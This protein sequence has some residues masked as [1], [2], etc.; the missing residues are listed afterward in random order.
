LKSGAFVPSASILVSTD[1][2]NAFRMVMVALRLALEATRLGVG[3]TLDSI[4]IATTC[5]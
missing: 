4:A 5:V 1:C 3:R 2:V